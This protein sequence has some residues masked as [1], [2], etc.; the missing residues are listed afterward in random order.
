MDVTLKHQPAFT[1][2]VVTLGANEEIKVEPGAMVSHSDGVTM[3]TQVQGGFFGGLKRMVGGE[4]FFQNTWKAPANGGEITL[5]TN[6]LGDMTVLDLSGGEYLLHSGAYVSSEMAVT[7]DSSWGGSKAFFGGGGLILLR[8]GGMGKL[9]ASSFGAIEER[10]LSAGQKYVVDTGHIVGFE[11]SIQFAVKKS[12]SWKSTI[13]GGEG[14][15]CELTGPG[16]ILMQTR[17]AGDFVSWLS[18]LLPD[19]SSSS[20]NS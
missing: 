5:T 10:V 15:V 18:P 6:L 16:R 7:L 11:A 4:S 17:A 19:K 3:D 2:A 12:G 8:I 14:L 13:L 9:I 1:L 20:S